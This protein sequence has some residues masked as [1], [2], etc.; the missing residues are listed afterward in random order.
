MNNEEV[1]IYPAAEA[2]GEF[3]PVTLE[4]WG[5]EPGVPQKGQIAGLYEK[6]I[7]L[8]VG[9]EMNQKAKEIKGQIAGD[10]RNVKLYNEIGITRMRYGE[11]ED[12]IKSLKKVKKVIDLDKRYAS[13][14]NN[15]G[16]VYYLAGRYEEALSYYMKAPDYNKSN[17]INI[18]KTLHK[19]G[20]YEEAKTHYLS[21][22]QKDRRFEKK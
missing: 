16:N 9:T 5:W 15:V 4:E 12:A 7:E 8:L 10:P 3:V 1:G 13:A 6:D 17:L 2:W 11:Y 20:N 21:A 18:E 14:Y 19:M 22:V